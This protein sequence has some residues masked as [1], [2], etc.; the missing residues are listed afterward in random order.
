MKFDSYLKKKKKKKD[1]YIRVQVKIR[2]FPTRM[3]YLYYISCLRYTILVRKPQNEEEDEGGEEYIIDQ[4]Q[5]NKKE[6]GE[7]R[8]REENDSNDNI[9]MHVCFCFFVVFFFLSDWRK[10]LHSDWM[11]K[12]R[13]ASL[14][15]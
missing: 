14:K 10:C 13:R 3:V 1:N 6:R 4:K 8:Q 7:R 11:W 12:W 9:C 5:K 2:G 15:Q